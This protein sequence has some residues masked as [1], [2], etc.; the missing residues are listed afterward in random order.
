MSWACSRLSGNHPTAD[1]VREIRQ[2]IEALLGEVGMQKQALQ[3][4]RDRLHGFAADLCADHAEILR[5]TRNASGEAREV[6]GILTSLDGLVTQEEAAEGTLTAFLDLW[7]AVEDELL[8]TIVALPV[9]QDDLVPALRA[10]DMPGAQ[11]RWAQ[12]A[13]LASEMRKAAEAR[14]AA[15]TGPHPP[16]AGRPSSGRAA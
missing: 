1:Q 3:D 15:D 8:E 9:G 10:L 12:L 14:G 5:G 11:D 7:R 4:L 2:L 13:R 16:S 6:E